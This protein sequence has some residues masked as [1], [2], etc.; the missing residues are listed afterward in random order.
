[1][2][3]PAL[4]AAANKAAVLGF[5]DIEI[6]ILGGG[7]VFLGRK[8][9]HFALGDNA[10]RIGQNIEHPQIF[11]F[12]HQLKRPREQKIANQNAFLI[13]P[14]D[15]RGFGAAAQGAFIDDIIMQ[16]C[17][18][19][20]QFNRSGEMNVAVGFIAKTASRERASIRAASACRQRRSNA[21]PFAGSAPPTTAYFRELSR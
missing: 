20:D 12:D 15:I 9:H 4:V 3:A 6:H 13:A 18:S 10:R 11:G 1:M 17:C 16:Q 19:M 14:D 21:Q 2:T 8:L 7:D 5:D